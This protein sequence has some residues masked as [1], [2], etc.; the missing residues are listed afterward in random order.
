MQIR[1]DS[2][3]LQHT[4]I[5]AEDI[6]IYQPSAGSFFIKRGDGYLLWSNGRVGAFGNFDNQIQLEMFASNLADAANLGVYMLEE[7]YDILRFMFT[8]PKST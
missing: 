8:E 3:K 1:T 6:L 2:G 7:R 4:P 5:Q